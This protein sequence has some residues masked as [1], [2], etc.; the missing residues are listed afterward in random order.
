MDSRHNPH[1][2]SIHD[3]TLLPIPLPNNTS[4]RGILHYYFL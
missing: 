3:T 4:A 2:I 1:R